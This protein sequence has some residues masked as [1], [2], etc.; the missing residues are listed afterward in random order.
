MR[1]QRCACRPQKR[2]K[3]NGTV[4]KKKVKSNQGVGKYIYKRVGKGA[5]P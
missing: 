5:S 3:V 2:K 4:E 1:P